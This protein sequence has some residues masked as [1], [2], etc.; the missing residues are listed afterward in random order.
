MNCAEDAFSLVEKIDQSECGQTDEQF[1]ISILILTGLRIIFTTQR[2]TFLRKE[3]IHLSFCV[4]PRD[5]WEIGSGRVFMVFR[6]IPTKSSP[7]SDRF[8]MKDVGFR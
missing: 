2:K 5:S 1:S 3:R 6:R 4:F 8:F 7:D